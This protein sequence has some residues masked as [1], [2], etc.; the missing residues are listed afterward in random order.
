MKRLLILTVISC[1]TVKILK[2][3]QSNEVVKA[4]KNN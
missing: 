2:K 3:Y 1:V 4:W